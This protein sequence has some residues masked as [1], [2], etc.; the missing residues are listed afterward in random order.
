MRELWLE[1]MKY[2]YNSNEFFKEHEMCTSQVVVTETLLY[3]G[4]VIKTVQELYPSGFL[5]GTED[6]A[7]IA[8]EIVS[9]PNAD[10]AKILLMDLARAKEENLDMKTATIVCDRFLG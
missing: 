2:A 3:E 5:K 10:I 8:K 7:V 9:A 6:I 1:A 4:S